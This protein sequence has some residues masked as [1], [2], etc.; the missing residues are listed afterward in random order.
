MAQRQTGARPLAPKPAG[1][2]LVF[3]DAGRLFRLLVDGLPAAE[4][5]YNDEGQ[6]IRKTVL[7]ATGAPLETTIFHYDAMGYL[8][9]ETTETGARNGVGGQR[10]GVE[11]NGVVSRETVSKP[12]CSR[13]LMRGKLASLM[14]SMPSSVCRTRSL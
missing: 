1:R 9:S 4:Y 3:N 10:N 8:I 14:K 11:R 7:D 13:F 5:V 2:E 12:K 6:R